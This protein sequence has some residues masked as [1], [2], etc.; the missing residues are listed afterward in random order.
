MADPVTSVSQTTDF[1]NL[2]PA[3]T[4]TTI[5]PVGGYPF[6]EAYDP[7]NARLFV[8]N[9]AATNNSMSVID[10]VTNRV[11]STIPLSYGVASPVYDSRDGLVYIGTCCSQIYAIDANTSHVV[12]TITLG[13]GCYPGCAPGPSA[14]DP[15]DGNTYFEDSFTNNLTV[16]HG[17]TAG[18]IPNVGSYPYGLG[19]DD[20]NGYLYASNGGNNSLTVIDARTNQILRW[21]PSVQAGPAIVENSANGEMF[22]AGGNVSGQARVT[23]VDGATNHVVGTVLTRNSSGGAA[24][25]PV[26]GDVYVTQRYNDN[27]TPIDVWNVTVINGTTNQLVGTLPTQQGPIGI[28]Y[29][30]FNHEMYVADSDTN[31]VS[32]LFPL[33]SIAFDETG[34]PAGTPWSVSLNN[35]S[36]GSNTSVLSFTGADGPFQYLVHRV[37]GYTVTP[38]IG[39]FTMNGSN[40]TV[41]VTFAPVTFVATFNETGLPDGAQWSVTING[42]GAT[43]LA[44]AVSVTLKN[45]TYNFTVNPPAG[46]RV[47][48]LNGSLTI[49]GT[50]KTVHL[51]F[52]A[53]PA[54]PTPTYLGLTA[55]EWAIAIVLVAIIAAVAI[56]VLTRRKHRDGQTFSPPRSESP[57]PKNP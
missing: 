56:L 45:G 11:V 53:I 44:Q 17:M 21:I 3:G 15:R 16:I 39:S 36:L 48:P 33:R 37:P 4:P 9:F 50:N 27:Y 19:Y 46:F 49:N 38:R 5:I 8:A 52:T 54:S 1:V 14:Y 6:G 18:L 26:T 22:V 31:N 29:G 32:L 40:V 57:P 10:T 55:S 28:A 30:D 41:N 43:S 2:R 35:Q 23:I 7:A 13:A 34:L 12:A 24:F 47:V 51:V 42:T 25:D 20:K